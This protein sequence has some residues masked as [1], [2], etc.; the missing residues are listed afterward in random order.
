MATV[1]AWHEALNSSEFDTLLDLSSDDIEII[2]PEQVGQGIAALKEW[3][4]SGDESYVPGRIYA[5]DGVV[6]VE[7]KIFHGASE[8]DVIK[9]ASAF[10]VVDDQVT[11][12]FRHA[13]IED[14]LAA[15]GLRESDRVD[16][17]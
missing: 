13:T 7:E 3:A 11:S 1:L 5:H 17:Q 14:A 12:M 4:A 16:D 2:T 15:T 8:K 9:G 10:R 6:V